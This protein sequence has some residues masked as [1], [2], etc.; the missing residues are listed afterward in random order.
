MSNRPMI[1]SSG[2]TGHALEWHAWPKWTPNCLDIAQLRS[3]ALRASRLASCESRG[4]LR[5][6][7]ASLLL[8]G[9]LVR[10]Y[11]CLDKFVLGPRARAYPKSRRRIDAL[12]LPRIRPVKNSAA[13]C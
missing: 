7:V 8:I 5:G 10:S 12:R 6:G 3:G 4:R 1:A 2:E 13:G 11:W 9:L